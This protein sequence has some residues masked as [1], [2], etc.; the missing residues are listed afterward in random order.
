MQKSVRA[1]VQVLD[2]CEDSELEEIHDILYGAPDHLDI[3]QAGTTM[4]YASFPPS[5]NTETVD[6]NRK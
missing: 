4:C 1:S 2:I 6:K 3:S 5:T